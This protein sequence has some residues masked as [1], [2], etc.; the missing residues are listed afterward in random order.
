[1]IG[2]LRGILVEQV[3]SVVLIDCGGVGYEVTVS[4]YTTTSLPPVSE[5]VTLRIYTQ[6]LENRIAL[7]GFGSALE[8]ELFD[9]LITVK[10]VG[11]ASAMGILSGGLGPEQ[12]AGMIAR[13]EITQLTRLR[14]VGKKTAEMLVVE[15]REKCELLLASWSAAGQPRPAH[16]ARAAS[17]PGRPPVLEEVAQALLQLGW[18]PA[19]VD[20]VV[21]ELDAGDDATLESLLRQALRSMP[22]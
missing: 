10:K 22:R 5:L 8:R 17:Q 20:K 13:G 9:L 18:R 19:A 21:G 14:G 2:R 6:V 11:P 3:D 7:Y 4:A 1:M 16:V 12:I 15:L